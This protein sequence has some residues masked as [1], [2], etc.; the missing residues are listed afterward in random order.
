M[1]NL[2][3]ISSKLPVFIFFFIL[4][5]Q[6]KVL[7]GSPGSLKYIVNSFV[8]IITPDEKV[9]YIDP[10]S[11]DA[12]EDSADVV[13]ITHEHGDH[14][15]ISRV[16]CKQNCTVI[17][18]ADAIVSGVYNH[19]KIGNIDIQATAAYNRYHQ[20]NNSVGYIVRFDTISIY[21]AGDTDKIPEMA[22]LADSNITYALLPIDG[23]Y[24]MTAAKAIEAAAMINAQYN[25]P[26]HSNP[27][28]GY[29]PTKVGQF[30]V[31]NKI[32]MIPGQTIYFNDPL[33]SVKSADESKL[34]Y[35]L[36][37]NYPNPFNPTTTIRYSVSPADNANFE[38]SVKVQMKVF[39][40]YGQ[41]VAILVN[42]EKPA[43][44]YEVKFN[45]SNLSSGVYIYRVQAGALVQT[46]KMMLLK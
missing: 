13:L 7:G 9:I 6:V 2:Q 8:K 40:I 44:I 5:C 15:E 4:L 16:N 1:K 29:S 31:S 34:V 32:A 24:T 36:E 39:D 28:A 14:N 33:T 35:N 20:K 10:T 22:L 25:I 17:R 46:K 42:E 45:A 30:N 21:H 37:Q 3:N 26:I 11:V 23:T 38:S 19:F 43:G 41:E 27:P 18:S 12:F